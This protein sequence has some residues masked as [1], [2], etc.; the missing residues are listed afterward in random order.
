MH[1]WIPLALLP[2]SPK[3][4]KK[5]PG[6][7]VEDQELEALQTTHNIISYILRPLVDR[8]SLEDGYE[9]IC[10]DEK[11]RMCMHWLC[12][13]LADHMENARIHAIAT[14]RCPICTCPVDE[15][16][17]LANPS[18]PSRPYNRYGAAFKNSEKGIL[19]ADG[20]KQIN[21]ALWHIPGIIPS[22]I[23][24]PN[25]LHNIYLG[26]LV[27]L[28]DWIQS[29]VKHHN[30]IMAFDHI[31]SRLPPYPGFIQPTKSYRSVTQWQGKEMRNLGRV[32]LGVFT[33]TL[34]RTTDQEKPKGTQTQ[35]FKQAIKCVRYLTDFH[36]MAQYES[37]TIK[38]IQ[39]MREYLEKF[40]QY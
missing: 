15:L 39:Y 3:R 40:H 12:S 6:Y 23:A 7:P 9:M 32:I 37:H 18:H 19:A 28:M 38:T 5:I 36:L 10:A 34:R 22:D 20:V 25:L 31:W 33:A 30:C 4:I 2:I 27:H 11:V 14:N 29:F 24:K 26:I 1:A 17:D 13:W 21:N 35:E 8:P 16:G